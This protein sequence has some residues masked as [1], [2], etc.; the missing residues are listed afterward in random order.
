M[1]FIKSEN[2]T[3]D[4]ITGGYAL[5]NAPELSKVFEEIM[6][7]LKPGGAAAFLDF[8]RS[9][10]NFL[11]FLNYFLIKIWGNFWGW[12]FHGNKEVYGYIAESLK[13]FPDNQ[14]L[15]LMLKDKGFINIKRKNLFFGFTQII[16]FEKK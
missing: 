13:L 15:I 16:Y 2:S 11:T 5:R 14:N 7:V 6:R 4:L 8:A 9:K 1:C 3:F 10:N 12:F